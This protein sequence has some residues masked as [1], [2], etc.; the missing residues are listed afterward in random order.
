MLPDG[1]LRCPICDGPLTRSAN[2]LRCPRGH[3]FDIAHEG[4][5]NLLP[6][7]GKGGGRPEASGDTRAMVAARRRF[8]ERGYYDPLSDALN[9]LATRHLREGAAA[10]AGAREPAILDAGCGE[11]YYL[12]RLRRAL[13]ADGGSGEARCC[14]VDVS[15]EAVRAA[16]RRYP[17]CAFA[18]ADINRRLP[19]PDAACAVLL[20][21][22]AP[23]NPG[24]F[25]RVLAP[26]GL[27]L[28]VIPGPD[29]L[30]EVRATFRLLAIEEEK[31][32]R[33]IERLAGRF[34]PL[35]T[36]ALDY[37]ITLDP[38]VLRDLVAMTPNAWHLPPEA[39]AA[40]GGADTLR[41]RA[42][43]RILPFR[44]LPD[45]AP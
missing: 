43:F 41:T 24:G 34:A 4:Y 32:R 17:E 13:L 30:R 12:G 16:A 7:R 10:G 28:V 18:V 33:V 21:I 8:L 31:E 27:L 40:T 11:G 20:D 14:G 29:H 35:A 25:R 44:P 5:V 42:S 1:W 3:A 15:K 23:R 36:R 9:K 37:D 38:E 45:A 22:F 6:A 19:L 39:R 2:A 26:D